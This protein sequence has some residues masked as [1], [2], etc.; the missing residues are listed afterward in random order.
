MWDEA[1]TLLGVHE[2]KSQ[3]CLKMGSTT[4]KL[5]CAEFAHTKRHDR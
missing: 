1:V 4:V 3:H 5:A 2:T